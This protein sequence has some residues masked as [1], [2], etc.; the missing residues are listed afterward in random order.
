MLKAIVAFGSRQYEVSAGK[1]VSV[2][3][4]AKAIGEEFAMD[5]VLSV[6]ADG[7]SAG[8]VG[9][10]YVAGASVTFKVSRHA[11]GEKKIVFKKRSKKAWKKKNGYRDDLTVLEVK[12]ISHG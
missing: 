6:T 12:G 3:R 8:A 10:P 2:P 7:D 9:A 5:N 1:T 11:R 4:L